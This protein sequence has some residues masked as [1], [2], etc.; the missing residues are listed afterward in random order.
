M[1]SDVWLQLNPHTG[2]KSEMPTHGD[3]CPVKTEAEG[4]NDNHCS[5]SNGLPGIAKQ[6]LIIGKTEYTLSMAEGPRKWNITYHQYS[7]MDLPPQSTQ[8][9]GTDD[10][11]FVNFLN[12]QFT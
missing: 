11:N 8:D 1:Q 12:K 7:S 4:D 9:Y 5:S 6:M 2:E 3:I 10:D